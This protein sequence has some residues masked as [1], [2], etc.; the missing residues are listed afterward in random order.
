MWVNITKACNLHKTIFSFLLKY[1]KLEY[2]E[3]YWEKTKKSQEVEW[4][5]PHAHPPL[6]TC[7]H[8]FNVIKKTRILDSAYDLNH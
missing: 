1:N 6:A 8:S 5:R 7:V 2:Y 3:I 4:S